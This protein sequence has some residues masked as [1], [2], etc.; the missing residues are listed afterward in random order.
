MCAVSVFGNQKQSQR[1]PCL[2]VCPYSRYR[3]ITSGDSISFLKDID[4][5][6]FKSA[7]PTIHVW[8]FLSFSAIQIKS[9]K[10]N[11]SFSVLCSW[12]CIQIE[13]YISGGESIFFLK[14]W[15]CIYSKAPG[16]N[17]CVAFLSLSSATK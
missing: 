16:Q 9:V 4:L 15:T 2:V 10:I 1:A 12:L 14:L 5:F 7:F 3:S 13:I 11:V 6:L 8:R 17:T